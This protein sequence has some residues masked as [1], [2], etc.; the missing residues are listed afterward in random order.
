MCI[1]AVY[2]TYTEEASYNHVNKQ[3]LD[4][5]TGLLPS[6]GI[7][8]VTTKTKCEGTILTLSPTQA[9]QTLQTKHTI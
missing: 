9:K 7:Y 8:Q 2:T 4:P 5:A 6:V 1:W 3:V